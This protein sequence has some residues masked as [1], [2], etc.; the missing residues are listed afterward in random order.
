[1]EPVTAA[2]LLAVATGA[3]EAAGGKVWERLSSLVHRWFKQGEAGADA[4]ADDLERLRQ[5]SIA[6]D[7]AARLAKTLTDWAEADGTFRAELAAWQAIARQVYVN[8]VS[9]GD[10]QGMVVVINRV[11][12]L[13]LTV[14]VP[15]QPVS[16][17]PAGPVTIPPPPGANDPEGCL[18]ALGVRERDLPQAAA[19]LDQ[20]AAGDRRADPPDRF[21]PVAVREGVAEFARH[22]EMFAW[23][24]RLLTGRCYLSTDKV[25]RTYEVHRHDIGRA[26]EG[27]AERF[28]QLHQYLAGQ[29][30][31]RRLAF[32][33]ELLLL[34]QP[35]PAD[36]NT[37]LYFTGNFTL[38]TGPLEEIPAAWDIIRTRSSSNLPGLASR[39]FGAHDFSL[40]G[41][42]EFSGTLGSHFVTVT[43][44]RKHL[45]FGSHNAEE[46]GAS[47]L[48][49]PVTF[50]GFGTFEGDA[51]Q[52]I[53][54]R[55]IREVTPREA[56][57][58]GRRRHQR[59]STDSS[60]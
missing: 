52:P 42:L 53:L 43:V 36:G 54:L 18:R 27:A 23:P 3:S 35:L 40:P 57:A 15:G 30:G 5:D 2:L 29:A 58:A 13:P 10:N 20:V 39:V 9:V 49:K 4:V 33:P 41:I 22:L 8:S 59:R 38:N 6:L 11:D 19:W 31:P 16:A 14:Q 17:R 37:W 48:G 46:F 24:Q 1:V 12:H 32:G 7:V 25:S 26:D 60:E 34:R 55:M 44:S 45:T 28:L 51:L 50:A 47:L 56:G 21:W